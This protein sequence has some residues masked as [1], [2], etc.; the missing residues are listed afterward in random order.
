VPPVPASVSKDSAQAFET[1]IRQLIANGKFKTALEDAKEFHKAQRT[2]AS[3]SLL[4]DAYEARIQSLLDQNLTVEA[5]SLLDLVRERFP[6]AQAR[7]DGCVTTV[8]ARAGDLASLLE[9]LN[10]SELSADRRASIDQVI[11]AHVTDLAA[12][13]NCSALSPDHGLR[14]AAA[15]LDRAFNH[16]TSGPATDDEI[17][18]PEVSYRSPLAPWKLLIRAI[19]CL[20]RGED[21]ACRD[22]LGAI[23]AESVPFRLVPAMEA[24]L[25]GK[26]ATAPKPAEATLV[27]RVSVNLSE[28]RGALTNLD[29]AFD[30]D[31]GEDR[32]LKAVRV[33]VRECQRSAPERLEELKQIVAVRGEADCLNSRRLQEALGGALLKNAAFFR[34]YALAMELSGDDDDLPEA[35]EFWDTFRQ[36]AVR[37]GWFRANSVEAAILYLHMA[38]VSARMPDDPFSEFEAHG[39]PAN[40]QAMGDDCYFVFPEKLY[41]RACVIDPHP[42][43][44]AQWMHWANGRSVWK[45]EEVAR[46]WHRLR[47]QDIEP[48]LFLMQQAEKRNAFPTALSY[49]EKA[50]RIDAVHSEVRAARLRL[51]A[52]GAMS[53]L[54]KKKPHLA[55]Q[56][57]AAMASLPQSQQG[58]RPAFLAALRHLI[59]DASG[60]RSGAAEARAETEQLLNGRIAAE[61]L[62]FGVAAVSK[63]LSAVILPPPK[64]LSAAERK[65]I[66]ASLA[67]VMALA[68]DLGIT[69]FQLPVTYFSETEAQFPGVKDN[70]GAEQIF[71]LGQMGMA[72]E[73]PKL[74][75]MA[76]NEGLK[77]G[78]PL[79]ARFLLLRARAHPPSD[80][81][82]YF[83]L[84]AAAAAL[85]RFHRD[86]DVIDKA[87]EIVRNPLGG[88][89]LSLTLEQ[90]R[91][92]V[93]RELAAPDFPNFLTPAPDYTDLLPSRETLCQCPDCRRKRGE[94]VAADLDLD[95]EEDESEFDD[96]EIEQMF[97][98]A[99]PKE[100]P[101]NLKQQLLEIMKESLLTGESPDE[102]MSRVVGGGDKTKKGRRRR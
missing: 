65:A 6:S 50:D 67:R 79:E 17:A 31:A 8:S 81:R 15:A 29:R 59:C 7:L 46:E 25:G 34:M 10:H 64:A 70:L 58:D 60:D 45:A 16:V 102:I 85:G 86:M 63:R 92:V 78:G 42:E 3:E 99:L 73:H 53:H 37:E 13:A 44:F 96:A 57:L 80:G 20:H 21:Q 91:D 48:L 49:L 54:Q 28:L 66:P 88:S 56:K 27:S 68:K 74:A 76:S 97:K 89:S 39:R 55:A 33:A 75:W 30:D 69:K 47:P 24:I 32:I 94:D 1:S 4:V 38:D 11:L 101:P 82:R 19:A 23:K 14:Q 98:D 43:A 77:R 41:A 83:V 52:S 90:A 40:G 84:A 18:L 26:T 9:P 95:D 5:K 93:R 72:T 100:M 87:V 12:I 36:E 35:C 22:L 71:A 51:L 62:I 61:F 2:A